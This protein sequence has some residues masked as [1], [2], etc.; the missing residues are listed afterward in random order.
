[1]EGRLPVLDPVANYEK[2]KRI[3]EGTYGVVYKA[4]DRTTGEIVALKKVRMERERDGLPVTSMREIRVLQMCRHP[5]IV[6]LKKVVTGSKPDSIFLVFEYC[7]HDLGKL[8]DMMP[9][10]FSQSEVK[11]LMLQL[12]EAVDHLHSHWVMSRDLKL[13]NLLLTH[14]GHLKICDFGLARYFHAHEEAYTPRVVT[15][16]YRAPEILLGQDTY[17]EAVDMWAVGCIFAEL[18]RNEPLFPAKSELETLQLM[19]NLLG[20]PNERIWPGF[21][22]LPNAAKTKFPDQP[23]NYVEKEYPN[24]S[25]AGLSLLNQLLTYDPNKRVTA[26][27]ALK[28]PYFQEQPLPKNPSNMPTFPSAHDADAHQSRWHNRRAEMEHQEDMSRHDL[29]AKHG[30]AQQELD[31]R[32]GDAFGPSRQMPQNKRSRH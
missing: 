27:Q 4:R 2:I 15:L 23:Y 16:W 8:I 25:V 5:N 1:M 11:C 29:A 13:P 21:L 17:T 10:P 32:F 18:L 12:L 26:R 28:H 9:R 31:L 30:R 14:D 6:H 20:A 24:V 19:T 7:S 22:K 3:G